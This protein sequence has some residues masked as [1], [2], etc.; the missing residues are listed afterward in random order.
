[1]EAGYCLDQNSWQLG[2]IPTSGPEQAGVVRTAGQE[3]EAN[4]ASTGELRD[5]CKL[6]TLN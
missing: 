2:C 4:D 3:L 1:M 6:P 5:C